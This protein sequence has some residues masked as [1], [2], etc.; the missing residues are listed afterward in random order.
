ME[1]QD[2]I[3]VKVICKHYKIPISFI[4]TLQEFELITLTIEKNDFFIT[5]KQLKKVEKIVRLHYELDINFEGIDAIH[6]LLEQV[7]SLK[8]EIRIL[9]NRLRLYEDL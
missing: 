2:L 1:T 7:E 3:P 4:N 9:H 6:N 5:K 8:K